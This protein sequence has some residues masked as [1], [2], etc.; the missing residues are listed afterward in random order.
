MTPL[1]QVKRNYFD[2]TRGVP[3]SQ[4]VVSR[5]RDLKLGP[6]PQCD[7]QSSHSMF[8]PGSRLN[9]SFNNCI[10]PWASF[11]WLP[12]S[13]QPPPL[14][15]SAAGYAIEGSLLGFS[16]CLLR[17]RFGCWE[18]GSPGTEACLLKCTL[19]RMPP[20]LLQLLIPPVAS[21]AGARAALPGKGLWFPSSS[22]GAYGATQW[23]SGLVQQPRGPKSASPCV[24]RAYILWQAAERAVLGKLRVS[25]WAFPIFPLTPHPKYP[26]QVP[27][28]SRNKGNEWRGS[29]DGGWWKFFREGLWF[30][31]SV[32]CF[33]EDSSG[34]IPCFGPIFLIS[35]ER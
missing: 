10:L 1:C 35:W 32:L 30:A 13:L 23:L 27:V 20:P 7:C 2:T 3:V 8:F 16:A 28:S 18:G 9:S 34:K 5:G 15:V 26:G 4:E 22:F 33:S 25:L 17:K 6:W 24:L 21:V 14:K 11:P 31:F 29:F 19:G 12:C